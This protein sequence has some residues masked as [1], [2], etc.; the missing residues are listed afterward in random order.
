MNLVETP[1]PAQIQR[2]FSG[3]KS[4]SLW[5]FLNLLSELKKDNDNFSLKKISKV[6]D[7]I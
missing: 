7:G 2:V 3:V 6:R 5:R 4:T 1:D